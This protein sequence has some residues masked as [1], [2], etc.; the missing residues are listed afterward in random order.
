M[1]ERVVSPVKRWFRVQAI[2]V[3]RRSDR[4]DDPEAFFDPA[5]VSVLEI[6]LRWEAGLDG[7]E[8]F[9]HL[10]VMWYLDRAARRRTVGEPRAAENIA[11]AKLVGFFATRTPRRPNPIGIGC[12]RLQRREGNRLYV[13]GLD[14]WDG[15]PLLDIKGYYPRDELRPD[16]TVPAWLTDLWRRRDAERGP[17]ASAAGHEL[18]ERSSS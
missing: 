3:V 11:G 13:T 7:L 10:V 8:E 9:S 12:P 2:G 1:V 16:A 14:A 4:Q 5:A 18:D 6:D 15:S 17:V